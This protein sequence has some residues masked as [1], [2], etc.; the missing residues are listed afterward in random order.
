MYEQNVPAPPRLGW[1]W[2]L[3]LT[4]ITLGF[5]GGIWL[6]IQANWAKKVNPQANS[7][8]LLIVSFVLTVLNEIVSRVLLALHTSSTLG[9]LLSLAVFVVLI[10]AVF[11]LRSDLQSA[12]IGIK[13]NGVM[14]FFFNAI[15]FQYHLSRYNNAAEFPAVEVIPGA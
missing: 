6:I 5:F 3:L 13:L 8:P 14:T 12:P 4:I 7:M 9:N 15:Y 1:G 11:R 2:V 10:V